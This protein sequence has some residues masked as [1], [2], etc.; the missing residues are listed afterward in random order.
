MFTRTQQTYR[1]VLVDTDP[2][3]NV[4]AK[5]RAAKSRGN[6]KEALLSALQKEVRRGNAN[7]AALAMLELLNIGKAERGVGIATNAFNRCIVILFEDVAPP[8]PRLIGRFCDLYGACITATTEQQ[9][10]RGAVELVYFLARAK[11]LR[12]LSHAKARFYSDSVREW[13]QNDERFSLMFAED[14]PRRAEPTEASERT[15]ESNRLKELLRRKKIDDAHRQASWMLYFAPGTTGT[16]RQR[17]PLTRIYCACHGTWPAERRDALEKLE[18]LARPFFEH[19]DR[20]VFAI[21]PILLCGMEVLN[22]E[23]PLAPTAEEIDSVLAAH[24]SSAYAM[25]DYALDLH[26]PEGRRMGRGA[27][28]FAQVGAAVNNQ[29]S[30]LAR[31]EWHALYDAYKAHSES[32][33]RKRKEKSKSN[34]K[35]KI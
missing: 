27:V 15:R 32:G 1:T 18:L 12:L 24:K 10:E 21:A 5:Y 33:K 22:D 3:G 28:H 26:T 30:Q 6:S 11:K 20:L 8:S 34:K 7:S 23:L 9:L 14:P 16:K 19:R 13:A 25:P 4:S 29:L 31:P 17:D 35:A 2:L